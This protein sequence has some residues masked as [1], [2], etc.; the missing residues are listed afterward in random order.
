MKKIMAVA[1]AFGLV[2]GASAQVK[3]VQ[4]TEAAKNLQSAEMAVKE[5][6]SMVKPFNSK[7]AAKPSEDAWYDTIMT[8]ASYRTEE[9]YYSWIYYNWEQNAGTAPTVDNLCDGHRIIRMSH[10]N[11]VF[12]SMFGGG[13]YGYYFPTGQ[14]GWYNSVMQQQVYDMYVTGAGATLISVPRRNDAQDLEMPLRYKLYNEDQIA[15]QG[16]M[17]DMNAVVGQADLAY[18][19]V[20]LPRDSREATTSTTVNIP[21]LECVDGQT[22][23]DFYWAAFTEPVVAGEGVCLSVVFPHDGEP[24]D[25][26]WNVGLL[27]S[28]AVSATWGRTAYGLIKFPEQHLWISGEGTEI[29][30][31]E[32]MG[33]LED[34]SLQ[35]NMEEIFFSLPSYQLTQGN[36]MVEETNLALA[37]CTEFDVANENPVD[38]YVEVGPVPAFDDVT[39]RST[40]KLQ[41]IE[42]FNMSGQMQKNQNVS[43]NT[44]TL[45]ISNLN[46]GMYIAKVYTEAGVA[47]KKFIVK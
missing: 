32:G 42:I 5:A 6:N 11:Y 14:S 28:D 23:S 3:Q 30:N 13:E 4:L 20:W 15:E 17:A 22:Q 40:N 35:P 19:D 33:F 38:K 18:T 8:Y 37:F 43:G 10:G 27:I 31:R 24:T 9:W 21:N 16:F 1:C 7:L 44:Y 29:L 41:R 2:A 36:T 34:E 47:T 25:S 12:A 45:D 39:F 46:A 26:L